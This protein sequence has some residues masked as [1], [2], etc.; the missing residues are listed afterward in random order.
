MAE[1]VLHYLARYTHRVAISNHRL[2]DLTDATAAPAAAKR[3]TSRA[4]RGACAHEFRV[5][6]SAPPDP[7][8]LI[9]WA[10]IAADA[11]GEL[12]IQSICTISGVVSACITKLSADGQTILWQQ[13]GAGFSATMAVDPS[14]AVYLAW[15]NQSA[16]PFV[17]EKLSPD[18]ATVVWKTPIPGS[19]LVDGSARGDPSLAVDS[20]GR[21]FVVCDAATGGVVARLNAA[22]AVDFTLHVPVKPL[23]IAVDP[24]G[25]DIVVAVGGGIARLASDGITWIDID[26][27]HP[28]VV[29][30]LTLLPNPALAVAANGDAVIYGSRVPNG[31]WVLQRIDPAGAVVFSK[32]F[33]AGSQGS[34]ALDAA[35]NAYITGYTGSALYAVR[36]SLAP[37]GATWLSVYA[38]DGSVLQTTY[39]PGAGVTGSPT[40]IAVD[41]DS[42]VHVLSAVAATAAP[43]RTG[44]F[45]ATAAGTLY[46]FSPNANAQTLSLACI[47]NGASFL[48]G[49]VAPGEIVSL[50]GSGLGPQQG[51]QP[52]TPQNPYPTQAAGVEVTFGGTPAPLLWVQDAQINA[53]VPWSLAAATTEVCVTY[54]NAQSNCL[55]LPVAQVSP[56]VFTVDGIHAAAVNQDGTPNSA[57]NPASLSSTVSVFGTGLG[58]FS[59]VQRSGGRFERTRFREC[60]L[61]RCER[62]ADRVRGGSPERR[63]RNRRHI[64]RCAAATAL[65]GASTPHRSYRSRLGLPT[66]QPLRHAGQ[67]ALPTDMR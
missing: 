19:A 60:G 23:A 7:L 1:H 13:T 46:R 49:P 8:S 38:P 31:G 55:A 54:N 9:V 18:G 50:F 30:P 41:A 21:A 40:Y 16:S 6:S 47:G 25:S 66:S 28:I 39:L 2:I 27:P 4:S 26:L 58:P 14:G 10:P 62:P 11:A 56:G 20:S 24:T 33:P 67:S 29:P 34:L 57:A 63:G 5:S 44:P 12:Y 32:A 36:N 51:V 37:C 48:T 59:E 43:T 22:G 53:A 42:A 52:A 61:S 64:S 35:G 65:T 17:V 3:H 45:G 15:G